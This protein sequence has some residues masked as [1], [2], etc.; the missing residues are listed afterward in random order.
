[1]VFIL[2]IRTHNVDDRPIAP[3]SCFIV[4]PFSTGA[5]AVADVAVIMGS[6]GWCDGGALVWLVAE[7]LVADHSIDLHVSCR[8]CLYWKRWQRWR[9][10]LW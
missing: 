3:G 7:L 1:M 6:A 9:R 5:F 4:T 10:S 2:N 8:I